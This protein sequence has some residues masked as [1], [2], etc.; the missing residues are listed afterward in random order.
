MNNK[1]RPLS[2]M[3]KEEMR[4]ETRENI[5]AAEKSSSEKQGSSEVRLKTS[6]LI[7]S[8]E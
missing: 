4:Q 8:L 7:L 2:E 6:H 1:Y 5:A 3:T